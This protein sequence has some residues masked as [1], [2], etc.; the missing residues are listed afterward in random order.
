MAIPVLPIAAGLGVAAILGYLLMKKS[1]AAAITAPTPAK[2]VAAN[3][4]LGTEYASGKIAGF[5]QGGVDSASGAGESL[6][7]DETPAAIVASKATA[8]PASFLSGYKDGYGAGYAAAEAAKKIS[9][10]AV[11]SSDEA[12]P[13][14]PEPPATPPG[15]P[16]SYVADPSK[17]GYN[18]GYGAGLTYGKNNAIDYAPGGSTSL[19][20]KSSDSAAV[21][22]TYDDAQMT[23]WSSGW[24]LGFKYGWDTGQAK[25]HT[26]SAT[27]EYA[28][29][30]DGTTTRGLPTVSVGAIAEACDTCGIARVGG[31]GPRTGAV[32]AAPRMK[33]KR[34]LASASGA[35]ER[36]EAAG[37]AECKA[38]KFARV[39]PNTGLRD[40]TGMGLDWMNG[41]NAGC[42]RA[43][44][45]RRFVTEPDQAWT[46]W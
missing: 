7:P 33:E 14:P 17:A 42:A 34:K 5:A 28:T 40:A 29:T 31:W 20:V 22:K 23:L 6:N 8:D 25:Y 4:A 39:D 16:K 30:E 36:G 38:G 35:Y 1:G 41:F 37:Y 13:P 2:N 26:T 19:G 43:R 24:D 12:P 27:T 45:E 11:A 3:K 21:N 44:R 15:K 18:T 10:Y 46:R 32:L 9:S